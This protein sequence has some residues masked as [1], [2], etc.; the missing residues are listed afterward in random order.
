M[1]SGLK[2]SI[3]KSRFLPS[4]NISRCKVA[5]Y[6]SIV[7]FHHTYHLGKY[8]GFPLL[9]GKVQKRDFNY[10]LDKINNRLAG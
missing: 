10:I 1:V 8:L 4:K 3:Q 9:T 6:E 7:D 2:V 5:K